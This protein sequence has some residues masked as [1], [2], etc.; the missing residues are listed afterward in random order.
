MARAVQNEERRSTTFRVKLPMTLERDGR[1]WIAC[2][3]ALEVVTQ[4]ETKKGAKAALEEAV[5]L[6][7]ESCHD[8]GV[9]GDALVELGFTHQG[10]GELNDGEIGVVVSEA[11][12]VSKPKPSN[13]HI[14]VTVPAFMAARMNEFEVNASC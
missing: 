9:L 5:T 6:W 14:Q 11:K 12:S 13:D 7:I 4:S 2:C 8:R 10:T 3:P 1:H